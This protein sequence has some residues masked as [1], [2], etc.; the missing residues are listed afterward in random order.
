MLN[1][2]A[3]HGGSSERAELFK[4]S[5]LGGRRFRIPLKRGNSYAED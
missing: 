2:A 4:S 5:E 1:G 3:G